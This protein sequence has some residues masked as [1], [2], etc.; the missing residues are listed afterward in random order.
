MAFPVTKALTLA[1]S[2]LGNRAVLPLTAGRSLVPQQAQ[3]GKQRVGL[4]DRQRTLTVAEGAERPML[5]GAGCRRRQR[6]RRFRSR[7]N[8]LLDSVDTDADALAVE[9]DDGGQSRLPGILGRCAEGRANV[10][11]RHPSAVHGG[12]TEHVCRRAGHRHG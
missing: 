1:S 3:I 5:G 8:Q 11:Q 6:G 12:D 2:A 9:A 10:Q 4:D 7:A